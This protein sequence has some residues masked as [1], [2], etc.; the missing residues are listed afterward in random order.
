MRKRDDCRA[1]VKHVALFMTIAACL[2]IVGLLFL[3]FCVMEAL[4]L[5][6]TGGVFS[7]VFPAIATAVAVFAIMAL[8]LVVGGAE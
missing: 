7:L 4:V 1:A 6:F 3:L 8:A 5:L 2:L